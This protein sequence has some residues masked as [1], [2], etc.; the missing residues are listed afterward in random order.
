MEIPVWVLVI[1]IVWSLWLKFKI[2][3][4]IEERASAAVEKAL[5]TLARERTDHQLIVVQAALLALLK[6]I[7]SEATASGKP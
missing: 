4:L 2:D 3:D 1:G 5:N 7:E 6:K